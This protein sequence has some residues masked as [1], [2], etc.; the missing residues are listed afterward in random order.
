MVYAIYWKIQH[1]RLYKLNLSIKNKDFVIIK[2]I[3]V[4]IFKEF[5]FIQIFS[6]ISVL[7]F[8]KNDDIDVNKIVKTIKL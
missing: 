3:H 6:Y 2:S 8:V 5:S 4:I 1:Q 7:I